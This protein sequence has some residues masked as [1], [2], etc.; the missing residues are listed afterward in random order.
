MS[1]P[2][3]SFRK[4]MPVAAELM[5]RLRD[6]FGREYADRLVMAGPKGVQAY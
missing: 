6:Q 1:N 2:K 5:D 4:V 3:G